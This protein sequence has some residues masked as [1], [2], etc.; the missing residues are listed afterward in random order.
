MYAGKPK[1]ELSSTRVCQH[2]AKDYL[3]S[4]FCFHVCSYA[5]LPTRH[6]ADR[7]RLLVVARLARISS[8][9]SLVPIAAAPILTLLSGH[10]FGALIARLIVGTEPSIGQKS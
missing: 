5:G 4:Y 6:L 1:N 10:R 7:A 3:L 9:A 8:L 2:T